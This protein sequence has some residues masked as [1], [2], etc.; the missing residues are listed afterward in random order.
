[1]RLDDKLIRAPLQFCSVSR[2]FRISRY[3]IRVIRGQK[4]TASASCGH[5]GRAGGDVFFRSFRPATNDLMI[6]FGSHFNDAPLLAPRCCLRRR[7]TM[8]ARR[9]LATTCSAFTAPRPT[10]RH[11]CPWRHAYFIIRALV[12]PDRN[13]ARGVLSFDGAIASLPRVSAMN[14]SRVLRLF[15]LCLCDPVAKSRPV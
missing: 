1:M 11:L 6:P 7:C 8:A 9:P 12:L 2:N 14:S 5:A 15:N 3:V 4:T 10:R 13:N